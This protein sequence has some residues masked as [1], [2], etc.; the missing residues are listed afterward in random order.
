MVANNSFKLDTSQQESH[1]IRPLIIT[2][3]GISS[4]DGT[5]VVV[6]GGAFCGKKVLENLLASNV[7]NLRLFNVLPSK[8]YKMAWVAP[9][10]MAQPETTAQVD[11]CQADMEQEG[12]IYVYG[13]ALDVREGKVMVKPLSELEAYR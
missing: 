2:A 8:F 6:V 9:V 5:A 1:Q 4:A 7:P 10:L 12:A 13:T 11:C 3:P